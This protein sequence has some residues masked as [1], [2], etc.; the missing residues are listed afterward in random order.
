MVQ[1]NNYGSRKMFYTE[2]AKHILCYIPTKLWCYVDLEKL[3]YLLR[4]LHEAQPA[5]CVRVV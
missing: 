3:L 1:L 4:M 2:V 5:C